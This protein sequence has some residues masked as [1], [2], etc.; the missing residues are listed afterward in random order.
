MLGDAVA[1][2]GMLQLQTDTRKALSFSVMPD[3]YCGDGRCS[4]DLSL[5]ATIH[6]TSNVSL[7]LGPSYSDHA[8]RNQYVTAVADPT[9]T[10]FYGNRYV[11]ADLRERTLSMNARVDW[12][13]TPALTLQLYVQPLIASG[14]YT[15]F[16]E[17]NQPRTLD[18]SVYGVDRGTI[19]YAERHL[20]GGSGRRR[21]GGAVHLLRPQLQL[22]LAAG[23][24]GAALGVPSG[25]HD[26]LRL[27]PGAQRQRRHRRRR[28]RSW[29]AT[30]A[31][32][33]AAPPD[34]IFLVKFSYWLGL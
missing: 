32:W 2:L 16:K 5:D 17:F 25:V 33:W 14:A 31:A 34:N 7:D 18:R 4:W 22:P 12:T 27:D 1:E 30:S 13:F 20:H 10:L 11:F 28:P 29:G 21:A 15:N 9:A 19:A 8:T 24:R 26:L 6:P 23:Q 3:Y